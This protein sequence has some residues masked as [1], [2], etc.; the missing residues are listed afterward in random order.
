ML[1]MHLCVRGVDVGQVFVLAVSMLVLYLC[2]LVIDV[3][4]VFVC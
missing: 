4:H 3:C 1:V 2:V